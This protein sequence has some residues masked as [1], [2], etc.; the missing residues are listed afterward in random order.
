MENAELLENITKV[1]EELEL[2]RLNKEIE[3]EE[4]RKELARTK[5]QLASNST[6]MDELYDRIRYLEKSVGAVEAFRKLPSSL[7]EVLTMVCALNGDHLDYTKEAIESAHIARFYDFN[8]AW[9]LLW[10]M[11]EILHPM[12][13]DSEIPF[14]DT[15]YK[16]K[17]GFLISM[18]EG[19]QTQRDAKLMQLRERQY[20]GRT[21]DV[22]PHVGSGKAAD[23]LRV[24][25]AVDQETKK[26]VIGHCGDHLDN[27]L[28]RKRS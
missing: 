13:F 24:H 16:S 26:L 28:T 4:L 23:C 6:S 21:I 5:Y 14:S 3:S 2:V 10:S 7:V 27:S 8:K 12:L 25:F 17:T 9:E 15:E 19:R 11:A 18:S 20:Q 22:T 1:R